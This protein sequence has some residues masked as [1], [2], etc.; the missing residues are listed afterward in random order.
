[1][2]VEHKDRPRRRRRRPEAAENEI[3]EA[4]EAFLK[5][6]PFRDM[7]IEDVMSRTGLSRPSFYEYFRDRHQLVVKLVDRLAESTYAIAQQWMESADDSVAE[8][9][10]T[11]ERLVRLYA[12]DGYLLRAMAD[13]ASQNEEVERNHRATIERLVEASSSRIR[14]GI[15]RG[16]MKP[17]DALEVSSALVLMNEQYL[18]DRFGRGTQSDHDSA[19]ETLV[20]IWTRVLYGL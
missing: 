5:E 14:M 18:M 2:G 9:R 17:M 19:I 6:H 10:R 3:L 7:T 11:A 15:E 20:T 13:A 1:M 12:H 16:A 4:A 8:L